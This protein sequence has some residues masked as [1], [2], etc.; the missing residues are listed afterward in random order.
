MKN[1]KGAEKV[2]FQAIIKKKAYPIIKQL[3]ADMQV[4]RMQ[5]S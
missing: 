4:G 1:E 3:K 5:D 2:E